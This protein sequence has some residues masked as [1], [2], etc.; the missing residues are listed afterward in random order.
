MWDFLNRIFRGGSGMAATAANDPQNALQQHLLQGLG[1]FAMGYNGVGG[2]QQLTA[3]QFQQWLG[4]G[5]I[6]EDPEALKRAEA[7]L[8]DHLTA[9]ERASWEKHKGFW[10]TAKSGT[11]YWLDGGPPRSIPMDGPPQS[12]C[13]HSLDEQGVP[14][15]FGDQILAQKLL[16]ETDEA[17]FLK[18][19]NA[20]R[21]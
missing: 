17:K 12:H 2:N 3:E 16:I 15:P 5:I 7:L 11:R 19:A 21:W 14:L 4:T 13:F 8:L 9:D 20:M 10:V 6:R 1:Q 18:T